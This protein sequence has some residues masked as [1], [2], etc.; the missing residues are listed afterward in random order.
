MKNTEK[1]T[2]ENEKKNNR[3][4]TYWLFENG[5]GPTKT[6]SV[7]FLKKNKREQNSWRVYVVVLFCVDA[8]TAAAAATFFAVLSFAR[9]GKCAL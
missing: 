6:G 3:S 2:R 4:S 7:F 8:A 1:N 5:N 9:W